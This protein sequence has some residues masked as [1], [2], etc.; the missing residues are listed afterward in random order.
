MASKS[1]IIN[2]GLKIKDGCAEKFIKLATPIV[3]ATLK[4]PGCIRYEF[5]QD[6]LDKNT[7]YFFE[8]YADENAYQAHR[9]MPYMTE[10]RPKR[11]ALLDKYLGVRILS[12]RFIS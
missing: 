7:F 10:F 6:V 12:E 3:E 9:T 11:E 4:E 5:L 1:V 8:E 2:A